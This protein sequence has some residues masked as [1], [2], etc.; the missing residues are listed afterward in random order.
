MEIV[1]KNISNFVE[2]T[3]EEIAALAFTIFTE[4][5]HD[6]LTNWLQAEIILLHK[7]LSQSIDLV[8]ESN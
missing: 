5:G 1:V 7:R 2:P 4:T 8:P 6:A 3:H